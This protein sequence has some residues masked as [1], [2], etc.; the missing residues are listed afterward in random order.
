[1]TCEACVAELDHLLDY[2]KPPQSFRIYDLL[3]SGHLYSRHLLPEQLVQVRS[4][5]ARYK[6]RRVGF[7]DAC[8]VVLSDESPKLPLITTDVAD[9]NVYMRGRSNRTLVVPQK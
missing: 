6:G 1:M 7:A 3:N 2:L 8:L 5:I 4:E 9:F